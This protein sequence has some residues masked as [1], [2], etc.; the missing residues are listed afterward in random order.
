MEILLRTID[1]YF[2]NTKDEDTKEDAHY[3]QW[4][5]QYARLQTRGA[6]FSKI[7]SYACNK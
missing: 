6:F 4:H 3:H 2:D 5:Y 1:F 7:L